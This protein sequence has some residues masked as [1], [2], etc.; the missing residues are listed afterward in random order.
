MVWAVWHCEQGVCSG[1]VMSRWVSLLADPFE[2][3]SMHKTYR[4]LCTAVEP[5][6]QPIV[7]PQTLLTT[8]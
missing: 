3:F 4:K 1:E 7:I 2:K 6:L 8:G 5:H